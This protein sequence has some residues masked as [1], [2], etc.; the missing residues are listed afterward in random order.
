MPIIA[1]LVARGTVVL[2][3]YSPPGTN[4][5]SIARRLCAQIPSTPDSKNSYNYEGHN[6]NYL[7]EGGLTFICMTDQDMKLRVPYAFLYDIAN[8][9]KT[10][11]K[12]TIQTA[13]ALQMND[14]FSRI[15][16]DRLDFFSNDRNAD[17]ITRV[18]GEIEDAKTIMV[19]NI[20]KVLER[21]ER[22]EMLVQKTEDMNVQSHTFKKKSTQLK[23]KM[24][25]QNCK[26][27]AL[28]VV[29]VA[30]LII[31]GVCFAL[32]HFGVFSGGIHHI[33]H[34]GSTSTS[35]T[36]DDSTS[37]TTTSTTST[38]TTGDDTTSTSTT[39]PAPATTGYEYATT[40][41]APSITTG[42]DDNTTS[43]TTS[44]VTTGDVTTEG[45]NSTTNTTGDD[46]S[47]TGLVVS[48]TTGVTTGST[49]TTDDSVTTSVDT[50]TT[51]TISFT[52]GIDTNTT[53]NG[54]EIDA[55]SILKAIKSL[56]GR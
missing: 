23:K 43:A 54:T 24:F 30:I 1:A 47:T 10:T 32:W 22:I 11:Y 51:T 5:P 25:W 55:I 40:G 45:T 8:R 42:S 31:G 33:I 34:P 21:G 48:A 26:L 39:G 20:D 4:F 38:S 49:N 36:G 27:C 19:K 9:F 50:N 15:L 29:V 53:T 7:V 2:A 3:E 17:K 56:L 13:S 44:D 46:T 28:L 35:T 37:T 14:T 41:A 12:G 6:F 16:R 52:T 18:K